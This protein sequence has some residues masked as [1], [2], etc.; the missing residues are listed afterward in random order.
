VVAVDTVG[1]AEQVAVLENQAVV[2]VARARP[3]TIQSKRL[4]HKELLRERLVLEI[5]EA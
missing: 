1:V 4:Q 5:A 2:V 3:I